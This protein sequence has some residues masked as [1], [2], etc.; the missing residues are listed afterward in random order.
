MPGGPPLPL[1]EMGLGLTVGRWPARGGVMVRGTSARG[2]EMHRQRGAG[3]PC[4]L[5][6]L[7]DAW[8][9]RRAELL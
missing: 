6:G 4:C 2:A 3:A 8:T 9:L 1:L 5:G 7:E